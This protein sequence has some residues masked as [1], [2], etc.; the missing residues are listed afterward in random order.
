MHPLNK[1]CIFL[2]LLVFN[3]DKLI[4][5]RLL[6]PENICS[7]FFT[8]SVLIN[9]KSTSN[10]FS[11]WANKLDISVTEVVSRFN[12]IYWISEQEENKL[13]IFLTFILRWEIS[14]LDNELQESNIWEISSI[15]SIFQFL[16]D[17]SIKEEHLLNM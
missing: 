4:F 6:H 11:L 16:I 13:D 8:F 2:T 10:K 12:F 17:K 1:A 9:D 14:K 15:S 5:F 7:I 3:P